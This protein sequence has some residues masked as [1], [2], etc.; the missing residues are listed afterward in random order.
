MASTIPGSSS[1]TTKMP[2][3]S[4][5]VP[6]PTSS[7]PRRSRQRSS[8]SSGSPR[9]TSRGFR[10]LAYVFWHRPRPEVATAE[11]E[12]AQRAFQAGFEA[13]SACFR[14]AQL[15]FDPEPGYEDWYLV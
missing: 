4:A 7:T 10:M 14:L 15:P 9:A 12:E 6:A 3:G 13:E 11:Y 5:A 2:A 1:A 8:R